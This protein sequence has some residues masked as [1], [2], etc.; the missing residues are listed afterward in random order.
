MATR[1]TVILVLLAALTLCVALASLWKVEYLSPARRL[2]VQLA[3]GAL[4]ARL[5]RPGD[6]VV[7]SPGIAIGG[8][9]ARRV[10]LA[11]RFAP[12][13]RIWIATVPAS[14]SPTQPGT[15]IPVSYQI[16]CSTLVLPILPLTGLIALGGGGWLLLRRA[17]RR[18]GHCRACGYDRRG[19]PGPCPECGDPATT[20][21]LRL[22]RATWSFLAASL[23][24]RTDAL[25]RRDTLAPCASCT[26]PHA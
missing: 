13:D 10:V 7:S 1:R 24:P 8:F 5:F 25:P 17:R 22:R 19:L 12:R 2:H 6:F 3:H 4:T 18:S 11:P 9:S 20:W 15:I 16:P 26:S 14:R 23:P 21:A